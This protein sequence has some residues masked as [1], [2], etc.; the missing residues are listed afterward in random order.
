MGT[1]FKGPKNNRQPSKMSFV[2][3]FAS[4]DSSTALKK[5]KNDKIEVGPTSITIK[6]ALAKTN[7]ARNWA[8][9]AAEK[10]LQEVPDIKIDDVKLVWPKREIEYG[11][12]VV[13]K[14]E[15]N[16]LKGTFLEKFVHLTLP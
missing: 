14:Q 12:T 9:R 3:Y 11:G 10:I 5:L 13:F 16:D 1:I 7:G 6:G 8:L 15:K 2:E 4:D